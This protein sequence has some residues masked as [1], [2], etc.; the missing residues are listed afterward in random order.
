[1]S[2]ALS[3][4]SADAFS[5]RRWA[6]RP[7]WSTTRFAGSSA[8]CSP[9]GGASPSRGAQGRRAALAVDPSPEL[10]NLRISTD[11][12]RPP[13]SSSKSGELPAGEGVSENRIGISTE[14]GVGSP[15]PALP[16]G[17]G[18]DAARRRGAVRWDGV[19][20]RGGA[21]RA[22]SVSGAAPVGP[23]SSRPSRRSSSGADRGAPGGLSGTR[24][25]SESDQRGCGRALC[26]ALRRSPAAVR[27]KL[28]AMGA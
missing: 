11:C 6:L 26:R 27:A 10:G 1:M 23:W 12:P 16:S 7:A 8:R 3:S 13:S 25:R 15:T 2:V 20:A 5:G 9:R 4:I 19:A 24:P 28:K 21:A 17:S 18:S 22:G 14:L